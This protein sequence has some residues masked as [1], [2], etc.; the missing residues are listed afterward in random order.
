M[1]GGFEC[2]LWTHMLSW[3]FLFFVLFW[4]MMNRKVRAVATAAPKRV[5]CELRR[6][7]AALVAMVA[8]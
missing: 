7:Q 5:E 3:F 2:E 4:Q 1:E 6:I 8:C